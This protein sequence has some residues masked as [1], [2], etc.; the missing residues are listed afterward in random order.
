MLLRE[1]RA[2]A[3]GDP[4]ACCEEVL[5]GQAWGAGALPPP[6]KSPMLRAGGDRGCVSPCPW[7]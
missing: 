2:A 1:G 7:P 6:Y 3:G 4:A 5:P